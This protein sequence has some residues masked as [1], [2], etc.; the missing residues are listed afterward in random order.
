MEQRILKL[1]SRPN[2][3]PLSSSELLAQLGL[4]RSKQGEL[5]R[6]LARLERHGQIARIKKGRRFALPLEADLIPGRIRMNRQGNGLFQ[7][8]DPKLPAM[9]IRHDAT[10]TALHGDYVLVRRDVS[11]R[12]PHRDGPS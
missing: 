9:R 6:L 12:G 4:P 1:L 7:P 2:Y 10:A 8:D 5:E 11:A 3:R